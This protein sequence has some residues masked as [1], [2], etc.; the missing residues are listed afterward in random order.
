MSF[1]ELP[2][3]AQRDLVDE[4]DHLY[5]NPVRAEL[6][7]I[8]GHA[9]L[10]TS[11]A[12]YVWN[13]A[14]FTST[15]P[16][17]YTFPYPHFLPHSSS[18]EI[19]IPR[20]VPHGLTSSRE[21]G[22][23]LAF[24]SGRIWYWDNISIALT[25]RWPSAGKGGSVKSGMSGA[26]SMGLGM[27][28]V[29]GTEKNL[30]M[31]TDEGIK[32]QV[33]DVWATKSGSFIITTAHARLH[34]LTLH[35]SGGI[36]SLVTQPFTLPRG[37]NFFRSAQTKVFAGY[38]ASKDQSWRIKSVCG[39]EKLWVANGRL[40]QG[41]IVEGGIPKF[42]NE[43]V[44][45]SVIRVGQ[46]DSE[47][48]DLQDM[49]VI[50]MAVLPDGN[51]A[52][53]FSFSPTS[54][55][56][57]DG[58]ALLSYAV[59]VLKSDSENEN[60]G[61]GLS[62]MNLLRLPYRSHAELR[63]VQQPKLIVPGGGHI[64]FALFSEAIVAVCLR[65]D[66]SYDH[67]I[68][69]K[70][71]AHNVFLGSER[72]LANSSS[73]HVAKLLTVTAGSGL[74]GFEVDWTKLAEPSFSSKVMAQNMQLKSKIE[75]AVF[76]GAN[77]DNP[78]SFELHTG[79]KGSLE[80]AATEVSKSVV[81]STSPYSKVSADVGST[82]ADRALRLHALITFIRQNGLLETLDQPCLRRL[83]THAE[84]VAAAQS[85]WIHQNDDR[86]MSQT[87]LRMPVSM[88]ADAI[89][90]YMT[91]VGADKGTDAIRSFFIFH[92]T[93][94]DEVLNGVYETLRAQYDKSNDLTSLSEWQMEAN[95]IYHLTYDSALM[96]MHEANV[97]FYGLVRARVAVTEVW[98][99]GEAAVNRLEFIY[100]QTLRTLQ[101]RTNKYGS[102]VDT[103][104][105]D[106]LATAEQKV[107]LQL[108]N[109][110]T[111]LVKPL[112]F[113]MEEHIR[114]MAYRLEN[115]MD[116][117]DDSLKLQQT[118][119]YAQAIGNAIRPLVHIQT[120]LAYGMAEHHHQYVA[121]VEFSTD[122][123]VGGKH[124]I[125]HYVK[126]YG[127]P[128]SSVLYAR[129]VDREEYFQ[130][131]DQPA[132]F[133][134][135]LTAFFEK[136]QLAHLSW[137]HLLDERCYKDAAVSL[138]KVAPMRT[139]ADPR[140]LVL[141]LGKLS[142]VVD[143]T[144]AQS[145]DEIP[146]VGPLQNLLSTF[147]TALDVVYLTK[148]LKADI[149]T[150]AHIHHPERPEVVRNKV[151]A[152]TEDHCRLIMQPTR[153]RPAMFN[154]YLRNVEQLLQGI[155]LDCEKTADL[156]T[157][158]DNLGEAVNDFLHGF[159][160]FLLD[161]DLSASRKR[162]WL[163]TMWRRVYIRDDWYALSNTSNASDMQIKAKLD[164]SAARQV[165]VQLK[166]GK[167]GNYFFPRH[168]LLSPSDAL[169]LP[170]AE[171]LRARYGDEYEQVRQEHQA[172][173]ALLESYI[174]QTDIE[175]YV[176]NVMNA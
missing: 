75:Q 44:F 82:L 18:L 50:S 135:Y 17:C 67:V 39:S 163:A 165:M 155:A 23:L 107:Q 114:H 147:D 56:S 36:P 144:Q 153:Q 3:D 96:E 53:L 138:L 87:G 97:A 84:I 172:D 123:V 88:L 12:C 116:G 156:Y 86:R 128:F 76:F 145:R 15:A 150:A 32:D 73:E 70:D 94:I 7:E 22:L 30:T 10:V 68:T 170:D 91:R 115:R 11:N 113:S 162:L 77:E 14:K 5:V 47:M 117:Y 139:E 132:E 98:L 35:S 101:E 125:E 65:G 152:F 4:E 110:L 104:P 1:G 45:E 8:S 141:S 72:G 37:A 24:P 169:A 118:E 100:N 27:G 102:A 112:C 63:H 33:G 74:V 161:K 69:L 164:G 34:L 121:L 59:A 140:E 64:A 108:K 157:L 92:I 48:D 133:K 83:S 78:L 148:R 99:T 62:L 61:D 146:A 41:W 160:L 40:I 126:K 90:G 124:K 54:S 13:Y 122:S 38:L 81:T 16:T 103:M 130:L 137:L 42:S 136:N 66:I 142:T 111:Q 6:D 80:W 29:K 46:E 173:A 105:V 109:Q 19:P 119:K 43:H 85:L 143:I 51:L 89:D 71:P 174:E 171:D 176:A 131:L 28:P 95:T 9:V 25:F 49:S 60:G 31:E 21:P 79:F 134:P 175:R 20:L 2:L 120:D 57:D 154:D 166:S 127:E 58:S 52:V 26:G 159:Q 129:Y 151:R 55:S 158:K 149:E 106:G 168:Y 167:I 93:D